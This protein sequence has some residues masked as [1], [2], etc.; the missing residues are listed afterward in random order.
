M[1]D[2]SKLL[3]IIPAWNEEAVLGDVLDELRPLSQG[4]DILVVSDGSVDDTVKV[5]RERG[6]SC[7]DLPLNLGV[8]GAM[9]AGFLHAYRHGYDWALQLDADG[10]HDPREIATLIEH[11]RNS[12]AD[13]VIGARFAGKGTYS[14]SGPRWWAMRVLSAV[15]SA[16]CSTTLTD[17]TSGFKLMSRRAIE[18]FAREYP[19]E[20]LGDTI[21]ALVIAKR[22]GLRISQVPVAMRPRAGGEPSQSPIKAAGFLIRAWFALL[23]SLTRRS[24]TGGRKA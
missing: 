12:G 16:V 9:R 22:S 6:V 13:V 8:G 10:Q 5:A 17:T 18:I 7:L 21:E 24:L 14:V 4:A 19:A 3:I 15:L 1:Q 11:A 20:Y 23:I 2:T